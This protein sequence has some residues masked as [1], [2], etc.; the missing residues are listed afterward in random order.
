MH[1]EDG[2][3]QCTGQCLQLLDEQV[4]L[5]LLLQ[6]CLQRLCLL[7]CRVQALQGA[8][9]G[10]DFIMALLAM[11]GNVVFLPAHALHAVRE[12]PQRQ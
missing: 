3:G 12:L 6:L 5:L 7:Q 4:F 2:A 11:N 1:L 8:R 9:H 10:A